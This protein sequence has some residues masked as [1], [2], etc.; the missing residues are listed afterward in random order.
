MRHVK[1]Q[2][3]GKGEIVPF[4]IYITGLKNGSYTVSEHDTLGLLSRFY[5][6][7]DSYSQKGKD[8]TD[9]NTDSLDV[10]EENSQWNDLE[11]MRGRR[12]HVAKYAREHLEKT[13]GMKVA[14]G[15]IDLVKSLPNNTPEQISFKFNIVREM[16]L[17]P[18][19]EHERK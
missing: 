2:H 4:N 1:S 7:S 5:L 9:V 17:Q 14:D 8:R 10:D 13:V 12:R 19:G 18:D 15:I 6:R 3:N 11:A 16:L